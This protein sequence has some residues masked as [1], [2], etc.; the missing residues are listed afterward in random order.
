MTAQRPR[1]ATD[2]S[3]DVTTEE[4][5]RLD[6]A[7][8]TAAA[9]A[10]PA[11]TWPLRAFEPLAGGLTNRNYRIVTAAGTQAV[12]RI[13]SSACSQLVIDR[14]AEF[15]NASIAA[16]GGIG[17]NVLGYAPGLGVSVVEWIEGRTFEA[18]DLDDAATLQQVAAACRALHTGPRFVSDFD[19][20][21]I[22]HRYLDV[23]LANGYR[24]PGRYEDFAPHVERIRRALGAQPQPRVPCHNDLLPANLMTAHLPGGGE[25]IWIIDYEYAGNN[26]PFFE[27]GN[28]WAESD[29]P[30][31]RLTDL[32]GAYLGYH[33]PAKFARARLY[34]LLSRYGWTLWA[35]IQDSVSELD[36]DFWSWGMQ[37]YERAV[38]EF[39]GPEFS[40]LID[41]AVL[42]E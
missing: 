15:R 10:L 41:D 31:E 37:K 6:L 1:V 32:V 42:P 16:A 24:L 5:T 9:Q 38:E 8:L 12:A 7:Q 23:V 2:S 22:A 35:S 4:S 29:L 36:F 21:A 3:A 26:D 17:P 25:R 13:S 40:R 30:P 20:F 33:S 39:T 34:A 28:L 14:D 11:V 27:L 18:S 19:M